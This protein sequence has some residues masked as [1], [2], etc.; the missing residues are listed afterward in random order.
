MN[1]LLVCL[2]L[3]DI[4]R[5]YFS[6]IVVG[7]V[8][9]SCF[10]NCVIVDPVWYS[11]DLIVI[12]L[13]RLYVMNHGHK[14]EICSYVLDDL[15]YNPRRRSRYWIH[16]IFNL[17]LFDLGS[18]MCDLLESDILTFGDSD[19]FAFLQD[20]VPTRTWSYQSLLTEVLNRGSWSG[21]HTMNPLVK[22]FESWE[23]TYKRLWGTVWRFY[24]NSQTFFYLSWYGFVVHG[25]D[26]EPSCCGHLNWVNVMPCTYAFWSWVQFFSISL[27]VISHI[28]IK[29]IEPMTV[30]S[31]VYLC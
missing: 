17:L 6:Q 16:F 9:W 1:L 28:Y 20:G 13:D 22:I 11:T 3:L 29:K 12:V 10:F 8:L 30:P 14:S 7:S 18:Q 25:L 4:D 19:L 15:F 2:V 21:K 24:Q 27:F 31:H 26:R 5:A 23:G